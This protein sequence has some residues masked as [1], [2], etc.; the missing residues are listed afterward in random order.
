MVIK[1]KPIPTHVEI[2][3]SGP[4]GNA[5]FLIA[6]ARRWA[7]QL[8]LDGDAII[9]EMQAGSYDNLVEVFDRHFGHFVTIWK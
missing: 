1:R 9:K 8:D 7:D 4:E 5:Y 2:D 3:L 6:C